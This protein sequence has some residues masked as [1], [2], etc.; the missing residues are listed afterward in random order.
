LLNVC[1]TATASRLMQSKTGSTVPLRLLE[2]I[3][4]LQ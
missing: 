1:P 2:E 4:E 3:S